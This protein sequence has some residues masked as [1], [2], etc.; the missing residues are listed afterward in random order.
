MKP[1]LFALLTTGALNA[2]AGAGNYIGE[3][4]IN[5]GGKSKTVYAAKLAIK[6]IQADEIYEVTESWEMPKGAA[7]KSWVSTF[8][9]LP[10]GL[11]KIS[12]NGVPIGCG[13]CV[14]LGTQGKWCDYRMQTEKGPLHVSWFHKYSDNT[15][16]RLGDIVTSDG[17]SFWNDSFA[18]APN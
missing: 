16:V 8:Q 14:V 11:L 18:L 4:T 7:S 13:Y 12:S 9:F 15:I 10:N 1:L 6:E 2:F 3:G 17:A 5:A